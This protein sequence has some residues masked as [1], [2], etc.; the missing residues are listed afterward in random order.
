VVEVDEHGPASSAAQA[1]DGTARGPLS[2]CHGARPPALFFL[3]PLFALCTQDIA[4]KLQ[5]LFLASI[6]CAAPAS[7][8]DLFVGS[9]NTVFAQS[10]PPGGAFQTIG[11]CGGVI[12]GMAAEGGELYLASGDGLLYRHRQDT[13]QSEIWSSVPND[14]P[15]ALAI[16]GHE[17]LI[18][19]T[20]AHVYA[21]DRSRGVYLRQ[22]D[23]PVPVTTVFADRGEAFAGTDFGAVMRLENDGSVSFLGTCG[24][25]I[26]AIAASSTELFLGSA[27][28]FIWRADRSTGFVT[29]SFQVA[30]DPTGLVYDQG[31]LYVAFGSGVVAR[32][33]AQTGASLGSQDWGNPISALTLGAA[34]AGVGYCYG[35][36]AV[37]PCGVG[38][39]FG[40]CPHHV[41]IGARLITYGTAS[42]GADDLELSVLDVPRTTIGRF[43]MGASQ[44]Q[45]PFGNGL[46]CAGAGG[47]GQFRY[48]VQ[49]ALSSGVLGAFRF[50]PGIV[51]HSQQHFGALG[52]IQPGSTW[53]FQAWFRD[54]Q[55][56]CGGGFNTSNGTSVTFQP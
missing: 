33:D 26:Q 51:G 55:N 34:P 28:A 23:T 24:S 52:V 20:N 29:T 44:A 11:A 22:W 43:Y 4:M 15:L 41:G 13:Q 47:Y 3:D 21:L 6:A 53:R 8:T 25:T 17:L 32:H 7:A 40:G 38:D 45:V 16:R 12:T 19:T 27:G 49:Q 39:T 35:D 37:C 42:V 9:P 56:P 31:V 10:S 5:Q 2:G 18:A 36:A 48:P 14:S 46:L 30:E 54:A 1:L 50:G